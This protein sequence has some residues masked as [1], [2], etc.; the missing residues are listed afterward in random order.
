MEKNIFDFNDELLKEVFIFDYFHNQNKSEIKIGFR[1]IFQSLEKTLRDAEVDYIINDIVK[2]VSQI[3][4]VEVP[5]YEY[6]SV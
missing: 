5:G 2:S 4:D 1:F 6:K 3:D